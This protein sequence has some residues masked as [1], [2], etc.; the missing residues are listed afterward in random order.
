MPQEDHE[1]AEVEHAEEVGFVIFPAADQSAEV[2]KPSEEA[3]DFPAAA[4]AAQFATVLGAL[5][6]AVVFVRRD[7]LDAVFLPEALVQ[8]I[9]VVGAVPD[10]SF[11]FG[12]CETLRDGGFD[13]L[14]FMRRS[15]GDAAG[16]RKT[17]AVCDRHDF[18]AFSTASRADSSA[19]FF[20]ELK[21]ASM[22]VSDRSSLPR[23]R[24]S[25]ASACNSRVRVPSR[26]HCWKRRWQVW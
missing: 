14:R 13:K 7:E 21:L 18:T 1:A 19:P 10:H 15:A 17:M 2:V 16:D 26:C 24:R 25:S 11:W 12:S 6:A 4:I 9:A 22:K 5:A 3:L 8:R 20:A 23:A